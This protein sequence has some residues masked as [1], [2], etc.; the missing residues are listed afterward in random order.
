MS[1]SC[2][3]YSSLYFS[4]LFF[5]DHKWKLLVIRGILPAIKHIIFFT[6]LVKRVHRRK[7]MSKTI[8][9]KKNRC[10]YLKKRKNWK[11]TISYCSV[12]FQI[13]CLMFIK[14]LKNIGT[15]EHILITLLTG[16]REAPLIEAHADRV[17]DYYRNSVRRINHLSHYLDLHN[18]LFSS[19]SLTHYRRKHFFDEYDQITCCK[20]Y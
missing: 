17:D 6:M 8:F 13:I 2:F 19:A 18:K 5:F 20:Q 14:I 7:T 16:D 11:K 12:C 9:S 15:A 10:V 3:V 1:L 4:P